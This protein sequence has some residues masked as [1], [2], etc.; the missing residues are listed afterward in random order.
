MKYL[1]LASFILATILLF[2]NCEKNENKFFEVKD[3]THS[4]CKNNSQK[5]SLE[6]C[7]KI[8][9]LNDNTI[10]INHVNAVFNCCPGE[11]S[12]EGTIKNDTITINESET[13]HSCNCICPYDL[14]YTIGKL[15]YGV[16]TIKLQTMNADYFQFNLNFNSNTDTTILIN[17]TKI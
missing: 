12:A 7:I 15:E 17:N 16:Y 4:D 10:Q 2:T 13:E 1:K 9:T 3:F 11:L 8:K 14:D 6:E 5:T